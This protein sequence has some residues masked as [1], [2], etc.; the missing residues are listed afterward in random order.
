MK[1]RVIII[2]RDDV[3]IIVNGEFTPDQKQ[4][5]DPKQPLFLNATFAG[6]DEQ[7]EKMKNTE[8]S[9]RK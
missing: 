7:W 2:P 6:T 9:N 3:E 5:F 1:Q 4:K 8:R